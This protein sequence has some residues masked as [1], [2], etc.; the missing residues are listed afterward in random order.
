MPAAVFT[1]WLNANASRNYPIVENLSRIDKI[2]TFTIPNELIVAMQINLSRD[3]VDGLFYI[4]NIFSSEKSCAITIGYSPNTTNEEID[5]PIVVAQVNVSYEDYSPYKYYSFIGQN[6]HTS[7]VGSI[8]IGGIDEIQ[9]EG[10][11]RFE[12]DVDSTSIEPNCIFVSIPALKAVEI[13]SQSS[14]IHTAT[15]VLRIRAGENI[16]LTY[17]TDSTSQER[18]TVSALVGANVQKEEEC[19][20]ISG[21]ATPMPIKTINGIAPDEFC[22]F[23]IFGSECIRIDNKASENAIQIIDLCS[24]TCCGCEELNQLV[25]GIEAIK[26]QEEALIGLMENIQNV[27]GKMITNLIANVV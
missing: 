23:N 1:E 22:N 9:K 6:G 10:F 4:K 8:C 19:K 15:D 13:Y 27:Q 5:I 17:D 24:Q 18:I 11:G 3:Y 7:I 12:F 14:L 21:P 20:D 26:V 25:N 2:G 16:K